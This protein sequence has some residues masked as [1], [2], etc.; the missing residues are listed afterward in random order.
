[1]YR[2]I[3][4]EEG[5]NNY[6]HWAST[7]ILYMLDSRRQEQEKIYSFEDKFRDYITACRNMVI[8]YDIHFKSQ[9]DDENELDNIQKNVMEVLRYVGSQDNLSEGKRRKQ[10]QQFSDYN[11]MVHELTD[12]VQPVIDNEIKNSKQID[13]EKL[14]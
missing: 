12:L 7:V 5:A 3:T 13:R 14:R 6:I 4:R 10:L 1:M 9:W 2:N 8:A 11:A